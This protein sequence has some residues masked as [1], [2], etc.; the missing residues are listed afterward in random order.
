MKIKELMWQIVEKPQKTVHEKV[1]NN[2]KNW[3]IV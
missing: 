1:K 2:D 3:K